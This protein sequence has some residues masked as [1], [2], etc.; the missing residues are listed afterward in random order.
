MQE[1]LMRKIIGRLNLKKIYCRGKTNQE[2]LEDTEVENVVAY[3]KT[4]RMK[5]LGRCQQENQKEC[6]VVIYIMEE[7]LE[8]VIHVKESRRLLSF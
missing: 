4:Q 7:N 5:L 8:I 2:I 3:I 6:K 1:N